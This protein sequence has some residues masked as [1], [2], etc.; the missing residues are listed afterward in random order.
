M[1]LGALAYLAS[2]RQKDND[3]VSWKDCLSKEIFSLNQ[4]LKKW[5]TLKTEWCS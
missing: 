1:L 3:F 5:M 2:D 4:I